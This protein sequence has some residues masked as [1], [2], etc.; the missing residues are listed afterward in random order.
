MQHLRNETRDT[1]NNLKKLI[2]THLNEYSDGEV[3]LF[4]DNEE[5]SYIGIK[6]G[7]DYMDLFD[8]T[9]NPTVMT[10][11]PHKIGRLP[12]GYTEVEY[13]QNQ[14]SAYIN[15][16]F[17]NTLNTEFEMDFQL[18]DG[19]AQDRKEIGA[20]GKFGLAQDNGYWRIVDYVWYKTSMLIDTDRHTVSTDAGKTYMDETQIADRYSNKRAATQPMLIFAV[21]NQDNANPDGNC[22]LMKM[23]SCKIYE[24]GT[25]VRDYV[26]CTRDSDSVAG[27]Y[28]IVNDV[29]YESANSGYNFVAGPTV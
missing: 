16:G 25:L 28:D 7:T 5:K 15:T 4:R 2:S 3:L 19:V 26:P 6:N 17:V 24:S 27:A 14:T 13:I 21:S 11:D 18:V 22:A 8:I 1:L 23:Y 29:F 20:G 12:Y 10:Y 9:V